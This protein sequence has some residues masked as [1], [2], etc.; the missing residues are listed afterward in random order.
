MKKQGD[1]NFTPTSSTQKIN[2]AEGYYNSS[3]AL[4]VNNSMMSDIKP[5]ASEYKNV[6]LLKQPSITKIRALGDM[7]KS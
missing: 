5:M 4:K 3:S 2:P 1:Y 6:S 7:Q